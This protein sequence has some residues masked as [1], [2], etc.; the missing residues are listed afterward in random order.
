MLKDY[1]KILILFLSLSLVLVGCAPT[2]NFGFSQNTY[3]T[4]GIG[5][6]TSVSVQDFEITF[7][8]TLKYKNK[9]QETSS[10]LKETTRT[11]AEKG[12]DSCC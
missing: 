7:S 3:A 1:S 6:L 11:T 10:I 12:L 4:G 2:R 9:P 5:E 8:S